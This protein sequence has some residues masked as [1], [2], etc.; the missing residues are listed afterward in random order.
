MAMKNNEPRVLL[1]DFS[2][3]AGCSQVT[4]RAIADLVGGT[5]VIDLFLFLPK[6]YA[7]RM[8][9]LANAKPGDYI[10][11]SGK[12]VR[13]IPASRFRKM[14]RVILESEHSV[15]TLVF[16]HYKHVKH[17]FPEN[18]VVTIS[19]KV[20]RLGD[21]IAISHPDKII[22]GDN[23]SKIAIIDPI[24]P[25]SARKKNLF[26]F[27]LK[28]VLDSIGE[29]ED[30]LDSSL[31]KENGWFEFVKS[32]KGLHFPSSGEEL[33]KC[34]ERVAFDELLARM[35]LMNSSRLK[36]CKTLISEKNL[37]SVDILLKN[38]GFSLTHDQEFAISDIICDQISECSNV[39]LLQG[40]VG[41][42]KT[43]VAAVSI[44]N[45]VNNGFQVALVSPTEIL[46][47]QHY[48]SFCKL[49]SSI[50]VSI[51]LLKSK[52]PAPEKRSILSKIACGEC[53]IVIGTH[54]LFQ[55]RVFFKDLAFIVIDEQQRFGV[56]QRMDIV[57]KSNGA[58]VLL[59]TAT[60]IPRTFEQVMY[61][62]MNISTIKEKPK[63]RINVITTLWSSEKM[64][65][66]LEKIKRAVEAGH[67]IYW[68]CQAIDSE[69]EGASSVSKRF[70]VLSKII[71]NSVGC[72][73]GK[74]KDKERII[75]DFGSGKIKVL[76]STTVIE[77]GVDVPS[78]S[79]MVVEN[80]ECFGLSQLHQ[81]RG[82]VGRG[83][84]QGYCILLYGKELSDAS[85][86]RLLVLRESNDGFYISE[87][88]YKLR[89]GGDIAGYKQS[90]ITD[91]KL[92]DIEE[93]KWMHLLAIDCV[94][95]DIKLFD[96][97]YSD[98]IINLFHCDPD[99]VSY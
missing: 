49:F 90:G 60:P 63:G 27:L 40:D 15:V 98:F 19:G 31:V 35:M 67:S 94:Q 57:N 17:A 12:V 26:S 58:D 13:H 46:A 16:F 91:F 65:E 25:C 99:V 1:N 8:N 53:N 38:A 92:F 21:S 51:V 6:G 36:V 62:S 11:F 61:G 59:M 88:D 44:L 78:A 7:N 64:G 2:S 83:V 30:W 79:I 14:Y 4:H 85:K 33:K 75:R 72:V 42:G 22:L 28:N 68:V 73:H 71:P 81:L 55:E 39:R 10:T 95:G 97:K 24:Y 32:I 77:V 3:I 96:F 56:A 23:I 70:D 80:P 66:L 20:M 82:R 89:G 5:R 54:A 76:V 9:S 93:H 87:Q 86:K 84:E 37:N 74:I 45:I 43:I 41:S 34:R 18:A 52:M 69:Q 29:V 48:H 47:E 50:D